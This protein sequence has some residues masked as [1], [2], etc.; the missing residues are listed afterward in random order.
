MKKTAFFLSGIFL[1]WALF[2]KPDNLPNLIRAAET[3]SETRTHAAWKSA[4]VENG[5]DLC[6][7]ED[8]IY[9]AQT[10]EENI[11]PIGD[12]FAY[13]NN[14]VLIY[15]QD[16]TDIR[17]KQALMDSIGAQVVGYTDVVNQYQLRL[18]QQKS[19]AELQSLCNSLRREKIVAFA[20]CNY[21]LHRTEDAVP[22]DPWY[23]PG[24]EHSE[25]YDWDESKISGGNWWLKAT[26]T[27]SAMDYTSYFHPIRVGIVDSGFDTGHEDLQGKIHFPTRYF[28]RSNHPSS[29]GTHVAG[30]ISANANN[31]IGVTGICDRAELM[32]VDWEPI[33]KK[34]FWSTNERI[35]TG[36]IALIKS[37]AK[38]INLSLGSSHGY[39]EKNTFMMNLSMN[40][41]AIFFSYM[42]ASLLSRGYDFLIVQSA[43]NGAKNSLPCDSV[44]NG[45]FCA[46]TKKNAF[47]G[48]TGI[49]KQT[50]LDHIM[51]VG[52]CTQAHKGTQFY[53]SS[54]SNYGKGVSIFAPGSSV[55]STDI[56]EN[57]GY[58]YKSG[59]SM[60]A[61]VVTG[62]AALTW[63]VNP[64]L[65]GAQVKAILCDP[66]NTVYTCENHYN[67]T[68]DIPTYPMINAK[69]AVEAA[70][71]TLPQ[72]QTPT[73]PVSESEE[74]TEAESFTF[75]HTVPYSYPMQASQDRFALGDSD[76]KTIE[77]FRGEIG[78]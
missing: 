10:S 77:R 68:I 16:G 50:V 58:G 28:Q 49:S 1:L 53:Q 33:E 67:D 73:E 42:T 44:F 15:F 54:F 46:I 69:L 41:D 65:T 37:G 29:H 17:E 43:G 13:V 12:W 75:H 5:A 40:L 31:K 22:D 45:S 62:I 21:A 74:S 59:T 19:L 60:A 36:V 26:Q 23:Y 38:V 71:R 2:I 4:A 14:E 35:F 66:N 6:S 9:F 61:P 18:S 30:I 11:I 3:A 63:S 39:D 48:L 55:F 56:Q 51:V 25:I 57:G 27:V 64:E 24:T 52:S 20:S 47:T 70:I 76:R 72:S 7:Y 78:E 8:N 34:Q 32:C